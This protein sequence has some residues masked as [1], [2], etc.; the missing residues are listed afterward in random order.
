MSLTLNKV[1]LASA[2]NQ[3]ERQSGYYKVNYDADKVGK[4]TVSAVI[5]DKTAP[6]AVEALL[7]NLPFASTVKGQFIYVKYGKTGSVATVS[8][9][10]AKK[11]AVGHINDQNGEPIM[12]AVVKVTG[13]D[14]Y[15]VT[16]KDGYFNL[17]D[18]NADDELEVA[19]IGK[20]TIK[21]KVG[22]KQLNIIVTDDVKLLDD[23]VVTGYQRIS[24]EN[25]TGAVAAV[26]SD[27]LEERY[28]ADIMS[29]LEGRLPGLV[30]HSSGVHGQDNSISIRG[31]STLSASTMPLVVVDGLPISGSMDD[32]NM[33][34]I[35]SVTIL[36]DAAA[37][38]IYGAQASNGVIVIETKRAKAGKV[39][40]DF[41]ADMTVS[42]KRDYS[43]LGYMTTNEQIDFEKKLYEGQLS[44]ASGVNTMKNALKNNP[45]KLSPI[46]TMYAQNASGLLSDADLAAKVE[47]LRKNDFFKEYRDNCEVHNFNQRYNLAIRSASDKAHNSVVLNYMSD[48][49][50]LIGNYNRN[51]NVTYNGNFK[52]TD[53]FS[54]ALGAN[55]KTTWS[56]EN[57]QTEAKTPFNM[58][59]YSRMYN[60]D[61]TYV[62]YALKNGPVDLINA[63]PTLKSIAFNHREELLNEYTKA[64]RISGRY[65]AHGNFN[66]YDGI[67]ASIQYQYEDISYDASDLHAADSYFCRMAYNQFTNKGVH[68]FPEGGVLGKTSIQA[69][70]HT[71]RMQADYNKTFL[72]KHDVNAIAGYEVRTT[73]SRTDKSAI[74]G[75]D[76]KSLTNQMDNVSF[77]GM[78]GLGTSYGDMKNLCNF[79]NTYATLYYGDNIKPLYGASETTHHF[80]SYYFNANY[81]Y[82]KRYSVFFSMRKDYA[83][84]FGT[85]PK[86]RGKPLY[87]LGASW[88]MENESWLKDK[89]WIDQLKL[90]Y[91]WGL[92]GN[93]NGNASSYLTAAVYLNEITNDQYATL[94][95]PPYDQ[96][97]WEKTRTH[98][99]GLDYSFFHGR[100]RGSIDWYDKYTTDILAA[101]TLDPSEGFRSV[102]MNNACVS[103]KGLEFAISGDVVRAT[104]EGDLNVRLNLNL[105]H[106]TNEVKE[107]NYVPTTGRGLV[108][109]TA[110]G[111]YNV[112]YKKGYPING[113]WSI[114]CEGIN[115]KGVIVFRNAKTGNNT[116][117]FMSANEILK[118]QDALVYSGTL[119]PKLSASFEPE[120]SWKGFTL[121]SMFVYYGGHVMRAD[122]PTTS[123]NYNNFFALPNYNVNA[124]TPD[125]LNTDIPGAGIYKEP[126]YDQSYILY[127][128]RFVEKADFIKMRNIAL[129]YDLP[130]S[131]CRKAG[132]QRVRFRVQGNNLWTVWTANDKGIDPEAINPCYGTRTFSATPSAT[133]SINVNF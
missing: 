84:L 72:G 47:A 63:Q 94:S 115:D 113:I 82:D 98:N 25:S 53:W 95:S 70:H 22:N 44:T 65:Y 62:E 4:Y 64:K 112:D 2:L 68:Y 20:Q 7:Q 130:R 66:I 19:Y 79:S 114:I 122:A 83:D 86:F 80:Y 116:P 16:D 127:A 106:N 13:T 120:I 15:A 93:I 57:N 102:T 10:A 58:Y 41:T 131:I 105:S 87:G 78:A 35:S 1:A 110:Y 52:F 132:L 42:A 5:K 121:S 24:R 37:A 77:A 67:K 69:Q 40:V 74:I 129:S 51:L 119:D 54:L 27:K 6:E 14:K 31:I 90:R 32:I 99:I 59:P 96:L 43:D 73:H 33:Q 133:F 12:G 123:I 50:Q 21:R 124:W 18:A 85:D 46:G 39:V 91:S 81:M 100:I 34:D 88:N 109:Y 9:T 8:Q 125:N 111:T 118:D 30:N 75:Y 107:L 29:A 56:K 76:D 49:G 36:K 28:S 38:A 60:E 71:W 103:N 26:K 104:K 45:Y 55:V 17:P 48:N 3:V 61:G 117:T 23:V 128:D 11:G 97:R 89:E 108:K 101:K 92:T 126:N